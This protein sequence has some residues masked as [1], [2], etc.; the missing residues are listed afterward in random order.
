MSDITRIA[1]EYAEQ[2]AATAH[3]PGIDPELLRSLWKSNALEVLAFALP[4]LMPGEEP[5]PLKA[6]QCICG[7]NGYPVN[8]GI[9]IQCLVH[10]VGSLS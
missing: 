4:R 2:K 8:G 7:P 9:S 10:G 3:A 5:E 1:E 6:S